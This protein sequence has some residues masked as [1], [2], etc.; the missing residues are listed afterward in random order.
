MTNPTS[1]RTVPPY[2]PIPDEPDQL[3]HLPPG[4]PGGQADPAATHDVV[5]VWSSLV[6][7]EAEVS[8]IRVNRASQA[9][10]PSPGRWAGWS[11]FAC[12]RSHATGAA[13]PESGY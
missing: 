13:D 6:G 11:S 5:I 2:Y 4:A 10:A 8:Q 7:A 12:R 9:S 1:R 3:S